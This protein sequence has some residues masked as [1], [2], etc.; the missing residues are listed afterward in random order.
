MKLLPLQSLSDKDKVIWVNVD[1]ISSI[2]E[3]TSTDQ[4]LVV[5]GDGTT[6]PTAYDLT[7]LLT[8]LSR[9][10]VDTSTPNCLERIITDLF[11][12]RNAAVA[13]AN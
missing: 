3:H 7:Q 2:I 4:A 6:I 13:S 10:V 8:A 5:T 11:S 9:N 12:S 1:N